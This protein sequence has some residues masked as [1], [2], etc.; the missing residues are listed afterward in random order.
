M[1][2]SKIRKT[3][4]LVVWL[5]VTTVVPCHRLW[6]AEFSATGILTD[7]I[8]LTCDEPLKVSHVRVNRQ[9]VLQ[10]N[11]F[12]ITFD[13]QGHWDNPFD[14]TQVKVDGEFTTPSGQV[15]S[16]PGFF[17]Q[18]YE[19][20]TVSREDTYKPVGDPMWKV[21]FAPS[22]PGQ[23]IYR[24]KVVND[25]Q[26]TVTDQ[27]TFACSPH[28]AN[29][30]FIRISKTNP[31]Y[32][33]YDDGTP[34]FALGTCKW[35]DKLADIETH[36]V[37]FARAGGNMTRNFLMRIGE[38]VSDPDHYTIASPPRP[39][40][41]FGKIDLDRAWRHDQALELCEQLGICQ[42]LA[43]ANG[44]CFLSWDE[45]RWNMSVYNPRHGGPLTGR[46]EQSRHFLTAPAARENFKRELRYFIARWGYS[47][48]VFSWNLWNEIDLMP[49]YD[50]LR[51]EA[52]EWHREMGQYLE[53]TDWAGHIVHT[54]FKTVNGDP[55]L[56]GLAEMDI[57][58]VNTYTQKDAAPSAEVW[59]KRHL[60]R[61]NKPVMFSEFGIG[62]GYKSEEG[63]ASHDP[64][65]I[66][67]HNGMWSTTMAGSAGTAMV[68]GWNWIAND[69]YYAYLNALANYTDG[70]PFSKRKWQPVGV[71]SF[72][73]RDSVHPAC[74]ADVYVEGWHM[75]Y[76]FPDGWKSREVF[77]IEPNGRV[78]DR[79][80]F[81]G[82]LG[83]PLGRNR[84]VLKME[85]TR[86][87]SFA[88]FVPE[89]FLRNKN[90]GSPELT[91][92][93]DD[94]IVV[95][96]KFDVEPS[97][98]RHLYRRFE[99]PVSVGKHI[100]AVENTGGG[101]FPVGYELGHYARREGPDLQV[102]GIQTDDIILLWLKAPKLTW[103]YS[104]MG[105]EPE[106]QPSGRLTLVGVPD[107]IWI[108]EWLDT[109]ENMWIKRSVERSVNG[110]L[111]LETPP[112]QK[113]V[114][115]RLFRSGE[116]TDAIRSRSE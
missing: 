17:Y 57:V 113:S 75:N 16:V 53:E 5:F 39:D 116:T 86:A 6:G 38:L 8:E 84:V 28:T 31:L 27:A 105:I 20:T 61:H 11:K 77:E 109:I 99:F 15:C 41:G 26:T 73:F 69:K 101:Y 9:D 85:Y 106:E 43:I 1:N 56:D 89:I 25:R 79:G 92:S 10:Y 78:K 100:I 46:S 74:Y 82:H 48:A 40:R 36:Y 66:M 29:H 87:G 63:Y 51:D 76:R 32:F 114:A 4:T 3:M 81:S 104:R 58:S 54:N 35:W 115:V 88:V 50:S 2:N 19:R 83:P 70:I 71:A 91:V 80:S 22:E 102:R 23:H 34:F 96:E 108:A 103:L 97:R 64:A 44:T 7:V 37:E 93:L 95:R 72:H 65:R 47:T 112:I 94:Q 45:N 18:A 62:H 33:E 30:G 49:N 24:V 13:L 111:T 98:R 52:K 55:A 110:T 60:A 12:E 42:Q 68:F 59:I 14:P 21:R 90:P 107:G 67:A